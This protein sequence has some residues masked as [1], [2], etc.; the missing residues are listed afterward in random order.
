MKKTVKCN[1][2][3]IVQVSVLGCVLALGSCNKLS[4]IKRKSNTLKTK[5]TP[6][7]QEEWTRFLDQELLSG[8]S[9]LSHEEE[10]YVPEFYDMEDSFHL[11]RK[12]KNSSFREL[13]TNREPSFLSLSQEPLYLDLSRSYDNEESLAQW[14][15]LE[16]LDELHAFSS[17]LNDFLLDLLNDDKPLDSLLTSFQSLKKK[18]RENAEEIWRVVDNKVRL[19]IELSTTGFSSLNEKSLQYAFRYLM[20]LHEVLTDF[21]QDLTYFDNDINTLLRR[22]RKKNRSLKDDIDVSIAHTRNKILSEMTDKNFHLEEIAHPKSGFRISKF[23]SFFKS[24]KKRQLKKEQKQ[25]EWDRKEEELV[26][27]EMMEAQVKILNETRVYI[28][29]HKE[30]MRLYRAKYDKYLRECITMKTL[31]RFLGNFI[32]GL[33]THKNSKLDALEEDKPKYLVISKVSMN[34]RNIEKKFELQ[35]QRSKRWTQIQ[36]SIQAKSKEAS[37]LILKNKLR[38]KNLKLP[39]SRTEI[40]ERHRRASSLHKELTLKIEAFL[41]SNPLIKRLVF[42]LNKSYNDM[43]QRLHKELETRI[44]LQKSFTSKVLSGEQ[45]MEIEELVERGKEE[46]SRLVGKLNQPSKATNNEGLKESLFRF[47]GIK[48]KEIRSINELGDQA[49]IDADRSTLD[50]IEKDLPRLKNTLE[51]D[52]LY[53]EQIKILQEEIGLLSTVINNLKP[54]V[55]NYKKNETELISLTKLLPITKICTL[56]DEIKALKQEMCDLEKGLISHRNQEQHLNKQLTRFE[57][58]LSSLLLKDKNITDEMNTLRNL[59]KYPVNH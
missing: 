59:P 58:E 23:T 50:S 47:L 44:M 15:N 48:P 55:E 13:S 20:V 12:Q 52:S 16:S 40:N 26:R 46:R 18:M 34:K 10:S 32:Q 51:I 49:V 21:Y 37:T 27:N 8:S 36:K 42:G 11:C 30:K 41:N 39:R 31:I 54:L 35:T 6:Q 38:P 25:Q 14:M 7:T 24:K 28:K 53:R 19:R 9:E 22:L 45:R 33:N 4:G 1:F 5:K 56:L 2:F 57:K 29:S 17:N 43:F 3:K